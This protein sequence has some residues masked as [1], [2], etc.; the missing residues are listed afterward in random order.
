MPQNIFDDK[1]PSAQVIFAVAC[2]NK[3]LLEQIVTQIYVAIWRQ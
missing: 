2:G 3:P 1:S